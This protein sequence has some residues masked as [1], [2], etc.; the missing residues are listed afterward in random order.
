[1]SVISVFNQK[2]GSGKTMLSVH[3][4]VAA[5]QAGRKVAIL[6]LDPQGSAAAWRKARS[7]P[8]GPVVVKVPDHALERAVEGA[9]AD[10][11]DFILI[12]CPPSVSPATGRMIGAADLV[13]VPVTPEPF[14]LAALPATLVLIGTKRFAFVLS[15]CPQKAPEIEETRAKLLKIGRPVYGPV[16]NWRSMW[17]SLIAGQA[18]SEYEPDG[19]PA[20]EIKE[21]CTSIMKELA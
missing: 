13:I 9:K 11:F 6:D 17:R 20:E 19:K 8:D 15:N 3:L 16:N 14:D 21:T 5:H 2:G 1:M 10:G 7:A 12:D 18:V 4:A